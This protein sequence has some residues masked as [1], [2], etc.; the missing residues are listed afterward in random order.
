MASRNSIQLITDALAALALPLRVSLRNWEGASASQP[1]GM[2]GP[3]GQRRES[4]ARRPETLLARSQP[5]L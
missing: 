5:T 3:S 1:A 2:N 4:A